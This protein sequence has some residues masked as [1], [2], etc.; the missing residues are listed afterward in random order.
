L[1][2]IANVLLEGA[3]CGRPV[4]S[5][6]HIGCRETF[7]DGVSGIMFEPRS[8]DALVE[9]IEKFI[10]IPYE[11]KREMGLAGRKKVEKEFNREVIVEAY[12]KAIEKEFKKKDNKHD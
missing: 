9:A 5:T 4:L 6:N 11:K 8:T 7:D 12:M 10:A 3:A 2:G 1:E